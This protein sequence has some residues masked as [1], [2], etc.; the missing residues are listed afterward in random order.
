MAPAV[1]VTSK[2]PSRDH[3]G[4]PK[5]CRA[6]TIEDVDCTPSPAT[7]TSTGHSHKAFDKIL[8][9]STLKL[10]HY[11]QPKLRTG[12]FLRNALHHRQRQRIGTARSRSKLVGVV[13]GGW[14]PRRCGDKT[15]KHAKD[16]PTRARGLA[17]LAFFAVH[18]AAQ[19]AKG[20]RPSRLWAGRGRSNPLRR[21]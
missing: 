2:Q 11:V 1:A 8:A 19:S 5:P 9:A 16:D 4:K 12:A 6:V 14:G 3:E 13:H 7:G 18:P 10:S 17:C 21:G 15:A 20:L